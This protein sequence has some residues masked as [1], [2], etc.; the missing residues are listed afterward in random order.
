MI[1][2]LRTLYFK[3]SKKL[4]QIIGRLSACPLHSIQRDKR[5]MRVMRA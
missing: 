4:T 1:G 3:L 5:V 2:E